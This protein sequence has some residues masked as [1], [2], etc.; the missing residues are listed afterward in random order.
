[1]SAY[2]QEHGDVTRITLGV[3]FILVLAG[4]CIWILRPFLT[5]IVWAAMIV[6]ATWPIL[7][8]FQARLGGNRLLA[9]ALMTI[10]ILVVVIGPFLAA[11]TT[12]IMKV[13]FIAEKLKTLAAL[14]LGLPPE[15]VV[16]IPLVGHS[17]GDGWNRLA[18]L[19][20]A[21]FLAQLAPY[22]KKA[23]IWFASHAGSLAAVVVQFFLMVIVS[24]ILYARGE[25]A[26]TG[27]RRFAR[28]LAGSHGEEAV[29]LAAKAVR[30][31]A[32]GIVVT[33]IIQSSIGG[34]GLVLSGIPAA[35]L[36]TAIIFILCLAQIGPGIILIPSI[37]WLYW[38]GQIFPGTILLVL[39]TV[40]IGIDN[41]IRPFLI[42]KGADIPLILIIAGV[43]GGL[44]AFGI[45]GLFIGPV[46]L[47]VTHTLVKAWISAGDHG[48]E[49]ESGE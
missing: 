7:M 35:A 31:V 8:W 40:A 26:A 47:A 11:V 1:M 20:E 24:A 19:S 6:V 22:A 2:N 17:I 25:T 46:V 44:L 9:A 36:L 10:L 15:W 48:G 49:A 32:L 12:I 34:I 14:D 33:A 30:G 38:S 4:A 23:V 3:L 42:K 28:R 21:E 18:R 27:V 13:D 39:S 43:I 16:R 37:I 29:I 45:M 5:S 41:F